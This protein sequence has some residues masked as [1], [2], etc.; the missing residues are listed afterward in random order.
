MRVASRMT[1]ISR[2]LLIDAQRV[3]DRIEVL[4]VGLRRR[5]LQLRDERLLAR[6]AAVPR[7][8]P[9]S[10]A[11]SAAGS[12]D[13]ASPSTSG[14]NGVK[15][16]RPSRAER[17]DARRERRRAAAPR[18]C[19]SPAPRR[20]PGASAG[21]NIRCSRRSFERL[22]EQRRLLRPSVDDDDRAR[23][24]DAGQIEEL[25]VLPERLLAGAL[26]RALQDRRRASPIR[27][28]T[29]AR[30]AANSSGGKISAPVNTGCAE[31]LASKR[32]SARVIRGA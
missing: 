2:G 9:S 28:M 27:S 29:F 32:S 19:R 10:R 22:Q 15:I 11:R 13:D 5:R 23:L 7:I 24:D 25:V 31:G 6:G 20:R 1:A 4:D 30:R 21:P 14:R 12:V 16:V 17:R 18:R 8:L 3:E 26:G